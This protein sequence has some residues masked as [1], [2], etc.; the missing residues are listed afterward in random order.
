MRGM[1]ASVNRQLGQRILNKM[2]DEKLIER[3]KGD[4]GYVYKPVRKNTARVD[5]I[6][7]D[8][9]LSEDPIW[10]VISDIA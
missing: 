2:M 6:L 10:A 1:G 3:I 4:E 7:T 8:L 9:T 5:R